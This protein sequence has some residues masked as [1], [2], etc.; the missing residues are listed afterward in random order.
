[1]D[2]SILCLLQ[3]EK[4]REVEITAHL[5]YK[6]QLSFG[7]SMLNEYDCT[8]TAVFS[9]LEQLVPFGFKYESL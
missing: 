2:L 8:K 9:I 1:M 7:C 5:K 4:R 6:H 3:K